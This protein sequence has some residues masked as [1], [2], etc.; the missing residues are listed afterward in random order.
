M[1]TSYRCALVVTLLAFAQ[2]S[3]GAACPQRPRFPQ[4]QGLTDEQATARVHRAAAQRQRMVGTL[5]AKLPGLKGVVMSADI[6]VAVEPP[7]RL[8]VAV[9]SFFQQPTQILVTDGDVVTIFDATGGEAVFL[10]GPVSARALAKVLPIPL[11]PHEV[12]QVFLARPPAE[13]RGRLLAVDQD[14][15]TYDLWLEAPGQAPCQ[16]T[17]RA[18]DDAILR[19]QHFKRDGSPLLDVVYGELRNVGAAVLPHHWTLTLAQPAQTTLL[20]SAT[21]VVFNGEA[22]PD[23]AFHLDPPPTAILQPL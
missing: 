1:S 19:W 23:T 14:N 2:L 6:D 9:R 12:V 21:D 13:A 5:K 17:V 16:L 20:F 10:R 11:W 15:G 22:L 18:S 8:S 7:A 4:L 3:A